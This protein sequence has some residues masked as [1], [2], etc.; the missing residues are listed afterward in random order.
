MILKNCESQHSY[1]LAELFNMSLKVCYFPDCWKVSLVVPVFKD[2]LFV[3]SKVFENILNQKIV[4]HLQKCDLFSDFLYSFKSSRSTADVLTV[5]SHRI[6]RDFN[7]YEATRAVA[8]NISK[9]F[10]RGSYAGFLHKF[11]SYGISGQILDPTSSF[12]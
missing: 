5:V 11:S 2:L 7:W 3:V 8:L 1:T 6:V 9:S 12:F 10:D 4:D